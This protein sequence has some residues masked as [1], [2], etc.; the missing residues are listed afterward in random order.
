MTEAENLVVEPIVD[1]SIELRKLAG[2]KMIDPFHDN[3]LI[4]A[5]EGRNECSDLH[6]RAIFVVTP[7]HEKFWLVALP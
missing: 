6:E 5:G 2:K 4:F 7:V 3:E 1:G